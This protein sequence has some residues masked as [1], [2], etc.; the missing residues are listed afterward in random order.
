MSPKRKVHHQSQETDVA[1][2]ENSLSAPAIDVALKRVKAIHL[3][4]ARERQWT[5]KIPC[6]YL[7][8]E[9]QILMA[10]ITTCFYSLSCLIVIKVEYF[11]KCIPYHLCENCYLWLLFKKRRRKFECS[12]IFQMRY[13][14]LRKLLSLLRKRWICVTR[15]SLKLAG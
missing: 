2:T 13:R 7:W 14:Y 3:A 8:S 10:K 1:W 11:A 9:V 6:K 15:H 5:C 4:L 12:K